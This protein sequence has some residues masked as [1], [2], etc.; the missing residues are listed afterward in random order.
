MI[1]LNVSLPEKLK[2]QAQLLVESGFYV[3]LSDLIRDSLRQVIARN[4]YDLWVEEAKRDLKRGKAK[5]LASD[6]DI[7]EYV[8]SL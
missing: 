6:T 1:T 7:D 8:K 3:S 5:V 4:R 2:T